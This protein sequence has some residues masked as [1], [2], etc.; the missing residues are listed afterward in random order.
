MQEGRV[1]EDFNLRS[2]I[3]SYGSA[4]ATKT[5]TSHQ[6]REYLPAKDV[7]W[8]R[9]DRFDS[10]I[11]TA[12]QHGR[13]ALYD[14]NRMRSSRVELAW[15]HEHKN[16]VNKLDFD[17][18]GGYLLLSGSQ[19][20]TVRIWDIREPQ[21]IKKR[22]P[23][24]VRHPVREVQWSPTDVGEF[25][26]CTEN[27]VIQRWDLRNPSVALLSINAHEKACYTIN[28]HPDGRHLVSGGFDKYVK[29]WDFKSENRKQKPAFSLRAPQAILTVRWRPPTWSSDLSRS[30]HWQNAQLATSYTDDDPRIHIW[31]LRR[32]HLPFRELDRHDNRPSD[33]L[34]ATEDLIW[35][36]GNQG[37]FTQSD[38]RYAPLV[39]EELPTS[40]LD[41]MPDGTFVAFSEDNRMRRLSAIEDSAA[42]FL[43][44]PHER[45]SGDTDGAISRSFSDDEV[46]DSFLS[47]SSKRRYSKSSRSAKSLGNTP[48]TGDGFPN[49]IPLD[50]TALNGNG[51]FTNEQSGVTSKV[52]G[53]AAESEIIE[54]LAENYAKPMTTRDRQANPSIILPNLA[55]AFERNANACDCVSMHRMAQSWRILKAV[56]IPELQEWADNNRKRRLENEAQSRIIQF[57]PRSSK[58]NRMLSPLQSL[59]AHSA[60]IR[61]FSK[62]EKIINNLFKGVVETERPGFE[63]ESTSNMTT[64]LAKPLPDSPHLGGSYHPQGITEFLSLSHDAIEPIQPLPP[65]VISS[66]STAAA[67]SNALLTA[68][69][70]ASP[71]SSP[72]QAR[73]PSPSYLKHKRSVTDTLLP[74]LESSALLKSPNAQQI[75]KAVSIQPSPRMELRKQE[76]RRAAIR[77]FR[78]QQRQLFTLEEPVRSPNHG[79]N[80]RHDSSESFPMFSA[81]TDSSH[82]LGSLGLSFESRKE[83]PKN[84]RDADGWRSG[85]ADGSIDSSSPSS[86]GDRLQRTDSGV[87]RHDFEDGS[88]QET[89]MMDDAPT[90]KFG[91]DGATESKPNPNHLKASASASMWD[92]ADLNVASSATQSSTA[93]SSASGSGVFHFEQAHAAPKVK[94]YASNPI[95]RIVVRAENGAPQPLEDKNVIVTE[96]DI[97]ANEYV[98]DDFRAIDFTLYE[99]RLP[100]AW[101]S[102]PLLCH[103]I[104]FDILEGIACAQ[105]SVHL[106][107]HLHPFFFEPVDGVRIH[108]GVPLPESVAE[109]LM[110]PDLCRRVIEGIFLN[111]F[112]YLKKMELYTAMSELRNLCVD[113]N[114]PEIYR[115]G[116][117]RE[118]VGAA[119]KQDS[120]LIQ[121]SCTRCANLVSSAT[122]VCAS[123]FGPRDGCPICLQNN[124]PAG[125]RKNLRVF[126]QTCGHSAHWDCMQ[127]WM[128]Q[129]DA[130]GECPTRG[131]GCDCGLGATRQQR[132]TRQ[133]NEAE[134]AEI[135]RGS[136]ASLATK[137]DPVRASQSPAVDKTR[138][139]L[140][141]SD[142]T[143]DGNN[144]PRLRRSLSGRGSARSSVSISGNGA[145]GASQSFGRRVRVVTPGERQEPPH[146]TP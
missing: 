85:G 91:L 75:S 121:I 27:G 137:R 33:I 107:M 53:V 21:S 145:R 97:R 47:A 20:K 105:F 65:S 96:E 125:Q 8:S 62:S 82:R 7:C 131:C 2:A 72:E 94:I 63:S 35:G 76:D 16:E 60:E 10:I 25:A 69:K 46:D 81:S 77:D 22:Q 45:L 144:D 24:N 55:Q 54:F 49:V 115:Q 130:E 139:H 73:R 108:T 112:V 93:A 11:A 92:L 142:A 38:V 146:P 40:A 18:T 134:N 106:L 119:L 37:M 87:A 64:P 67:A 4:Y 101:S 89:F 41:F 34:W 133:L 12:A 138:D 32:P 6:R 113:F 26:L 48:P 43:R 102:L 104:E 117:Q 103:S 110:R 120:F 114:Y 15:I 52:V 5:E 123:C 9:G 122:A 128:M 42:E 39:H 124:D 1:V 50:K 66:H 51:F 78:A 141:A 84:V 23:I 100:F 57:P 88:N 61:S 116:E 95:K 132:I 79:V 83:Q 74:T 70:D 17:P 140:R 136:R 71:P 31:D 111:H 109:R 3:S 127:E 30:A 13:I 135:I 28:W 99:P 126:C 44:I 129:P 80:L 90:A 58:S 14:V 86:A 36:V 118:P 98:Y 56:V 143:N 29:V 19:D 68:E 59:P